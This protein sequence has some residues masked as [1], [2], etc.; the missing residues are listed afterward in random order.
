MSQ[1]VLITVVANECGF[2]FVIDDD[3]R[4]V[5]KPIAGRVNCEHEYINASYIDVRPSTKYAM[6]I[7][8][9]FIIKSTHRAILS[10]R[11]TLLPKVS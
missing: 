8:H 11:N 7:Y 6:H 1:V 5:L 4:V 10:A 9:W 3:H 2:P